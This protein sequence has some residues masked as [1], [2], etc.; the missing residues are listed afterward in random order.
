MSAACAPLGGVPLTKRLLSSPRKK[1]G[2]ITVI[3]HGLRSTDP[4]WTVVAPVRLL[5]KIVEKS[6]PRAVPWFGSRASTAGAPGCVYLKLSALVAMLVPA[7]LV[8]VTWTVWPAVPGALG[9]VR[10]LSLPLGTKH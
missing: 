3:E 5:P 10:T 2:G 4:K 9:T 7:A 6:P 8:T 1:H